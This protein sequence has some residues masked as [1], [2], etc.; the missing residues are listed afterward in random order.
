M[1]DEKLPRKYGKYDFFLF[2]NQLKCRKQKLHY[3]VRY[4]KKKC[5]NDSL[6]KESYT[7][8][9]S[10]NEKLQKQRNIIDYPKSK[11]HLQ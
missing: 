10:I 7:S 8:E 6:S 1:I 2:Q 11:K 4:T 3:N 5:K 9:S